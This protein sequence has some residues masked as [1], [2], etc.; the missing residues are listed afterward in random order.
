[1]TLLR[2][3]PFI[4]TRLFVVLSLLELFIG[5]GLEVTTVCV[6]FS[7]IKFVKVRYQ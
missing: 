4:G 5:D 3:V 2:Q 1:M 6:D 7:K